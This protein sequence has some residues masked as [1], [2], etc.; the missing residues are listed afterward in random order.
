MY[1]PRWRRA[2][3]PI[4]TVLP[5]LNV[6]WPQIDSEFY[7]HPDV[8]AGKGERGKKTPRHQEAAGLRTKRRWDG[9]GLHPT[10]AKAPPAL[11]RPS[12]ATPGATDAAHRSSAAQ[13]QNVVSVPA[14]WVFFSEKAMPLTQFHNFLC[15]SF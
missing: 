12:K 15:N 3:D 4:S 6:S 10:A 2:F 8:G 11:P 9:N 7:K 13:P 14:L 5:R 1:D